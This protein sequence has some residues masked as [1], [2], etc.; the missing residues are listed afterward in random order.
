MLKQACK[1]GDFE[2]VKVNASMVSQYDIPYIVL[3]Y[4][5][6]DPIWLN[7]CLL[8][9]PSMSRLLMR[10][11]S[12][13]GGKK[14]IICYLVTEIGVSLDYLDRFGDYGLDDADF[15]SA[16][17][18]RILIDLGATKMRSD[19]ANF[20]KCKTAISNRHRCRHSALITLSASRCRSDIRDILQ[21][22]ARCVWSARLTESFWFE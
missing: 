17:M 19:C 9:A 6:D 13:R 7:Y 20:G 15:C 16:S 22:I 10:G 12:I 5:P 21:I 1:D 14:N 2:A 18:Q 4:A 11:L 3:R 8:I